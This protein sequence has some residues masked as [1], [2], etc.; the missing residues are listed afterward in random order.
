MRAKPQGIAALSANPAGDACVTGGATSVTDHGT[1]NLLGAASGTVWASVMA[2][3]R[4]RE[5]HKTAFL[6]AEWTE[7]SLR[8][9]RRWMSGGRRSIPDAEVAFRLLTLFDHG[10]ALIEHLARSLPPRERAQ[11]LRRLIKVAQR[12][13]LQARLEAIDD[14]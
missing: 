6:I 13:E 9:V 5:P 14:E 4:H 1:A 11:F 3:L 2:L 10:P 8:S 12:A 7:H